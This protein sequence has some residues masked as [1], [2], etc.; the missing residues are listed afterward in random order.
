MS[1]TDDPV[2]DRHL[3]RLLALDTVWDDAGEPPA[4]AVVAA[5]AAERQGPA[6][7]RVQAQRRWLAPAAAAVAAAVLTLAVTAAW[8]EGD[9]TD[10]ATPADRAVTMTPSDLVPAA[11][12]TASVTARPLGTVIRLDAA[13]LP[14]AEP[15]TYY[16]AWMHRGTTS[17]SAGTFHMRGGDGAVY[18]WSG[19]DAADFPVLTVTLQTEGDPQPS[20]RLVLRANLD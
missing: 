16:E 5:I 1:A 12:A 6:A 19:V 7:V 13:G 2:L 4:D 10:S 17:V 9:D 3:S 8:P 18:L 11:R 14:P 20:D 15:G